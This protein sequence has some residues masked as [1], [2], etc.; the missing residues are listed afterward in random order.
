MQAKADHA[1]AQEAPKRPPG[2]PP[3]REMTQK[4]TQEGSE[5]VPA[6]KKLKT[7]KKQASSMRMLDFEVWI[8]AKI[9]QTGRMETK[10][11]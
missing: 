10:K 7:S 5:A 2:E 4:W 3:W 6:R 8:G 11:D 1:P 9:M